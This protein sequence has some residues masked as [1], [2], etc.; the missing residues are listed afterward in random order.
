MWAAALAYRTSQ[1]VA[2]D[3][4]ELGVSRLTIRRTPG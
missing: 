3:I 4:A 2:L 1:T